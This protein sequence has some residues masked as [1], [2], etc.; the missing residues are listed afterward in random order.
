M[1]ISHVYVVILSGILVTK[2]ELSGLLVT[3]HECRFSCLCIYFVCSRFPVCGLLDFLQEENTVTR[4]LL[5]CMYMRARFVMNI[6][7]VHV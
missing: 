6:G 2:C 1:I 7:H 4:S 3:K 5:V